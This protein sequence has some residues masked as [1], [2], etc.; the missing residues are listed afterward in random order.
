MFFFHDF[1]QMEYTKVQGLKFT[2]HLIVESWGQLGG[3]SL[4]WLHFSFKLPY[5]QIYRR[6]TRRLGIQSQW[7]RANS[8]GIWCRNRISLNHIVLV[9]GIV[10]RLY[11]LARTC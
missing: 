10:E 9:G 4:M 7:F 2:F 11:L 8:S 1:P 3:S 5:G 6:S